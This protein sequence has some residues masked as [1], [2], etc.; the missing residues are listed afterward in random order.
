MTY[1]PW[2]W[3]LTLQT[4]GPYLSVSCLSILI[5]DSIENQKICPR[6]IKTGEVSKGGHASPCRS[7][8]MN[9]RSNSV[10]S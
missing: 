1:H 3:S 2:P 5:D 6:R 7:S 4:V 10:L 9:S 8:R